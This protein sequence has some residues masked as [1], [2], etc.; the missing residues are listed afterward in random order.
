M[1]RD[2]KR[3][4]YPS[5]GRFRTSAMAEGAIEGDATMYELAGPLETAFAFSRFR[6]AKKAPMLPLPAGAASVDAS[7]TDQVEAAGAASAPPDE[8]RLYEKL[9]VPSASRPCPDVICTGESRRR[10]RSDVRPV[11]A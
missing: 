2:G 3:D 5:E 10:Q 4:L 1:A 6:E 9:A 11:R 7:S 8:R